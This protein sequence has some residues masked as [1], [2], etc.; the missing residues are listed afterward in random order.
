MSSA[1]LSDYIE[2]Y[3]YLRDLK[4]EPKLFIDIDPIDPFI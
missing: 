4:P 2:S 1:F 3:D